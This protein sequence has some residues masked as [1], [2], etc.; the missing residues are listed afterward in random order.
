[1]LKIQRGFCSSSSVAKEKLTE[2]QPEARWCSDS[3]NYA[4]KNPIEKRK[5]KDKQPSQGDGSIIDLTKP[6]E[7]DSGGEDNNDGIDFARARAYYKNLTEA[8]RSTRK[9]TK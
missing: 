1:M 4:K 3:A 8:Q 6:F 2:E 5:I 9:Q 7:K